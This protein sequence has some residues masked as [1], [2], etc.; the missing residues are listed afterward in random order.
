MMLVAALFFSLC[1]AALATWWLWPSNSRSRLLTLMGDAKVSSGSTDRFKSYFEGL[2]GSSKSAH[3]QRNQTISAIS[4]LA[5]ELRAGSP[6]T[7]ALAITG[8]EPCVWPRT[9]K[10]AQVHTDVGASLSADA[11]TNPQLRALHACWIVAANSGSG[12]ALS[13]EKLAQSMRISQDVRT[14]LEAELAGPRATA[15]MLALL[16]LI[17]IGLGYL[18]GAEPLTWLLSNPLGWLT[19]TIGLALTA[20]GVWWTGRIAARVEQML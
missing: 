20:S 12:L 3:E 4:S 19:L 6:P 7:V 17:G 11:E 18:M 13:I 16:P 8:G 2:F 5:A 15:R 14:Q 1:T 9:Q 10:A